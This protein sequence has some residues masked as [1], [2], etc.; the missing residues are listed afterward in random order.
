MAVLRSIYIWVAILVLTVAFFTLMLPCALVAL[1]FDPKRNTTHWFAKWW[2]RSLFRINPAVRV[3]IDGED[4]VRRAGAAVLCS[5]HQSMADIIALYYLGHPFK[6][7]SKRE[8]I[9]VPL[10]GLSMVLAGYIFL[11]RGDKTSIMRCM[12]K[13]RAWLRGGV[14][15]MMFPEGT[16]SVDGRLKAFKDGA[17]RMAAETGVPVIPIALDG[18]ATLIRKGS[19]TFAARTAIQVRVGPPI[20]PKNASPEEVERLKRETREWILQ[21]MADLRKVEPSTLDADAEIFR[22]LAV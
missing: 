16:R 6:W 15:I 18:P 2:A 14:S 1:P 11:K 7:I 4:N 13:A 17:F 12:A 5:N 8:V 22:R 20:V 9:F 3:R 10:I 21:A 19:L